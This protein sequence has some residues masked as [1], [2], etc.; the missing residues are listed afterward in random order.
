M[1]LYIIANPHSGNRSAKDIIATLKTHSEQNV[2]TFFTRYRNDEENQVKQVLK[3]FQ[4]SQDKLLILG[5]DGTLSKVLYYW[6][7]EI[8]FA[9][10][11]IGSGNDFARALGLRK[12]P[13]QLMKSLE[14]SPKEITVFNYQK[15]LVL[16]SLDLGFASWVINHVEH[17][18]L[19]AKL[20]KY[21]L[22]NL[23]YVLTAIQCLIKK[24]AF[25]SLV[26]EN[27]VGESIELKDL[28]FFSLANNTYFGGGVMIWPDA[29]AYSGNL[30]CVY[31]K[32]ETLW[33]RAL[34]LLTL[35]LKQHKRLNYF[36]HQ[37]YRKITLKPAES[38]LIEI[39]GEIVSLD[40]VTL[41]P[42]KRYIY[43]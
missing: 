33:K 38:S 22:G 2:I 13:I 43:L 31:A 21:H 42:Q 12:N 24:P 5:G 41:S 9:Y 10:Y 4:C 36:Q 32:G 3:S 14:K 15:G 25:A 6:P 26:L 23:I 39:D 11:P 20:N 7:A 18:K 29:T 17:S 8:P 19:K 30:D 16:N 1:T 37:T 34:V 35:V 28:F 27:E 40:E